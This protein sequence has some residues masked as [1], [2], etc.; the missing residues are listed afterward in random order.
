LV[1]K[2]SGSDLFLWDYKDAFGNKVPNGTY[3]LRVTSAGKMI[4]DKIAV[5]R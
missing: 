2:L 3:L 5:Y 4:Q 1:R